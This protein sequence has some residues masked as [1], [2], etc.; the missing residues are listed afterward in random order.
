MR[1][2]PI[3]KRT[4]KTFDLRKRVDVLM[5]EL[6]AVRQLPDWRIETKCGSL[7]IS[8]GH[9]NDPDA[10]RILAVFDEVARAY[11]AWPDVLY[12]SGVWPF[13]IRLEDAT[14]SLETVQILSAVMAK[15]RSRLEA[16]ALQPGLTTT[17]VGETKAP[18]PSS[19]TRK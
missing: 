19:R 13:P 6:G 5:T 15:L 10:P 12:P 9:I 3:V 17:V 4:V 16:I 14:G 18:M 8:I 2:K 7:L 1:M 11:K